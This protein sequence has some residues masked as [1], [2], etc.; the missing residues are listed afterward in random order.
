MVTSA[1]TLL[2]ALHTSPLGDLL[3]L[4]SASHLCG[5]WFAD[6]QALPAWARQAA[7]ATGVAG[8]APGSG[9][10]SAAA[11][12]SAQ[13]VLAQ[14]RTQLDQYFAGQR[15]R[16]D[17][18]LD[19]SCGTPFQQQVWAALAR[20]EPGQCCSYGALAAAI[21]RPSAARAVGGALGRNPL[22]IVLPCHRVLGHA[23]GLTG[24]TGGLERKQRLLELEARW[25]A[26]PPA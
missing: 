11:A 5:L 13:A 16:F 18:P 6:E 26:A 24:Y 20:L 19:W 17:L 3:L 2:R 21:G 15:Q 12:A 22:G 25:L 23:G 7:D 9:S 8:A 4:A 14:A 10:P 1:P